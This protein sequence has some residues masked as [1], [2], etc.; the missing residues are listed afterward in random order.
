MDNQ[1]FKYLAQFDDWKVWKNH[2]EFCK[3]DKRL[4]K[5]EKEERLETL[6][7]FSKSL[8]N[9]FLKKA[10]RTNT[11]L[12]LIMT[13]SKES[14]FKLRRIYEVISKLNNEKK[15]III[16]KFKNKTEKSFYEAS[17][18]LEVN[19]MLETSEFITTLEPSS[20]IQKRCPDILAVD[21]V[22]K[23]SFYLELSTS[24][25]NYRIDN[26]ILSSLFCHLYRK[27]RSAMYAG[28][29]LKPLHRNDINYVK[30]VLCESLELSYN[31]D[32]FVEITPEN[33]SGYLSFGFSTEN[34]KNIFHD[35]C[36]TTGFSEG[37]IR[38]APIN[39]PEEIIRILKDRIRHKF[40]QLI[41]DQPNFL[42]LN[43][44]LVY[45]IYNNIFKMHYIV[46]KAKSLLKKNPQINAIIFW[47]D[48]P[49]SLRATFIEIELYNTNTYQLNSFTKRKVI[50]VENNE[51]STPL[52]IN[53]R[54][55]LFDSFL[56]SKI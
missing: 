8:G 6:L 15:E 33:N 16:G 53:S 31:N 27:N 2:I 10:H 42:V 55:K 48:L 43:L 34:E 13:D 26:I 28:K 45:F 23:E 9:K 39:E 38:G 17:S 4:S 52:S 18:F 19:L 44:R 35:W 37:N 46:I 50:V 1:K 36:T 3:V 21:P 47:C 49:L 54:K 51:T 5:R 29:L 24:Y 14:R 20:V 40:T 32:C 7:Y 22:S 25:K 11:I 56:K 41:P 12:S 30:K